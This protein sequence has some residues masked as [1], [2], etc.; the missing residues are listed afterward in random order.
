VTPLETVNLY[1]GAVLYALGALG[2]WIALRRENP[3]WRPGARL[4]AALGALDHAV[5]LVSMGVRTGHFP[6]L[7]AFEAFLFLAPATLLVA[8]AIDALRG[9]P[10]LTLATLPLSLVTSLLAIALSFAPAGGE[11]PAGAASSIWTALHVMVA[12]GS[13]GA[14]GLAF[15]AGVL[16]LIEHHQL[17]H[18]STGSML[19][20]MPAL[21]TVGRLNVRAL[22]VGVVLL[23]AGLLV[24]YFQAR[25]VY[26]RQFERLD[27][28]II[29]TTLTFAAY[30]AILVMSGRPAFKGRRTA[31]GSVLGFFLL[32]TNFWASVFWSTMHRFH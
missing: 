32:M 20:L 5:V 16:F 8:L 4:A 31:L 25:E 10:I 3:N 2:G 30:L 23:L 14:F 1:G 22:A 7:G 9:L 19:G 24:G 11:P 28:K 6:I 26:N 17:K 12:L 27:P 21:E 18:H 13:Y 29:L 15:V